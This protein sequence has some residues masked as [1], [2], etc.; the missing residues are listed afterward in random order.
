MAQI[1]ITIT[2]EKADKFVEAKGFTDPDV[3][4]LPEETKMAFGKR[5]LIEWIGRTIANHEKNVILNTAKLT[6]DAIN[7]DLSDLS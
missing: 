4:K 1:T 6:A 5:M 2:A 7:L 3:I